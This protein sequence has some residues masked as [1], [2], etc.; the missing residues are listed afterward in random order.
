[1]DRTP[2]GNSSTIVEVGYDA[3][4]EVLEILFI[5]GIAYQFFNVP[6]EVAVG[7]TS[8][9]TSSVGQY[10]EQNIRGAYSYTK[11]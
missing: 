4:L 6:E 2:I 5:S 10:F 7:L 3:E 9:W 1:M 11:L 8:P